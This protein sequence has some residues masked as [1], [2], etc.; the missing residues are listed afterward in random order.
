MNLRRPHRRS[1]LA[2]DNENGSTLVEFALVVILFLTV[3]FG[4]IDFARA[5]YA[6]HF[7]AHAAREGTRYAIVRGANC[8]TNLADCPGTDGP[9]G[10]IAAH[11]RGTATGIGLDPNSLVVN[12]TFSPA[13]YDPGSQVTTCETNATTNLFDNPGCMVQVQV[14]Y[15]FKS[16]FPLM[17]TTTCQIGSLAVTANICM[18]STSQMIISQ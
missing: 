13:N 10:N 17:P 2:I 7:V 3:F 15:A 18:N 12:P 16:I 11:V 14:Q 8:D 4:I 1:R 6:Y 5:L 9:D